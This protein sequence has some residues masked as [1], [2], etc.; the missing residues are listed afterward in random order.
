MGIY[1]CTYVHTAMSTGVHYYTRKQ[2][3]GVLVYALYD[4]ILLSSRGVLALFA[5]GEA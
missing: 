2:G 5:V 4:Y 3:E 1:V